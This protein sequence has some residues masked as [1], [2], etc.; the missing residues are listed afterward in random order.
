MLPPEE[1]ERIINQLLSCQI[2]GIDVSS[3]FCDGPPLAAF[4]LIVF[5]LF[6]ALLFVAAIY[7]G[8][9]DFLR[10]NDPRY[11]RMSPLE[12]SQRIR[13][14]EERVKL[15]EQGQKNDQPPPKSP[16]RSLRDS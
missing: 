1:T 13:L 14:L 3:V 10:R 11:K 7:V 16:I 8:I 4:V 9:R 15:L 5:Y 2:A 12:Q 6:A